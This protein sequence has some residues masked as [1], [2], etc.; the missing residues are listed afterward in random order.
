MTQAYKV[1]D[2][3]EAAHIILVRQCNTEIAA[4]EGGQIVDKDPDTGTITIRMHHFHVDLNPWKN[5][6]FV[7]V[8]RYHEIKMALTKRPRWRGMLFIFTVGAVTGAAL[9]VATIASPALPPALHQSALAAVKPLVCP[10]T[11]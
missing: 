6:I 2:H 9:L 3:I 5:C 11:H 4:G 8:E 7:P 1:G 10:P